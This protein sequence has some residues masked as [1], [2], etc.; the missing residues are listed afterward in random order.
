MNLDEFVMFYKLNENERVY[1]E[2]GGSKPL[3]WV[4]PGDKFRIEGILFVV[5]FVNEPVWNLKTGDR[6]A[7]DPRHVPNGWDRNPNQ[8]VFF[9]AFGN[10]YCRES[11]YMG[12]FDTNYRDSDANLRPTARTVPVSGCVRRIVIRADYYR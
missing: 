2:S 8:D 11:G 12:P 5:E 3:K 7:V 4:T 9:T 1:L 10:N 6:F